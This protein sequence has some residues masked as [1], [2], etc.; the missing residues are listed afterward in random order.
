M[1]QN[2]VCFVASAL[3]VL[4]NIAIEFFVQFTS[5]GQIYVL[6]FLC[7]IFNKFAEKSLTHT[8]TRTRK[9]A[10]ARTRTHAHARVFFKLFKCHLVTNPSNSLY[11]CLD[12]RV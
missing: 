4:Y 1:L 3:A 6:K 11:T 7:K 9:R 10:R 12:Q 2:S 5:S 8:Y